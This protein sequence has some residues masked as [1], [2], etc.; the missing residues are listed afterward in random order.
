MPKR[1]AK[2]L[3]RKATKEQLRNLAKGRA[4]RK[5]NLLKKRRKR[6]P[7]KEQLRNLAKGRAIRKSNLKRKMTKRRRTESLTGG[8]GDVNPQYMHGHVTMATTDTPHTMSFAVPIVRLPQGGRVTIVE[9]LKIFW[10][11]A[12]WMLNTALQVRQIQYIAFSTVSFGNAL[13]AEFNEANVFAY[14]KI[15]HEGAFTALGSMGAYSHPTPLVYDLTDGAGHGFLLATD[16][17]FVQADSDVMTPNIN[18]NDFKI[19]YRFKTVGLQ[20]YVGIV[21][22]QQ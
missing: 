20:E 21:Q 17:I 11:P 16:R 5:R 7:T 13:R 3:K 15:E 10:Q 1:K 9:V 4:I 8:T 6:K 12:P 18:T 14:M 19:L 2:K 22:S